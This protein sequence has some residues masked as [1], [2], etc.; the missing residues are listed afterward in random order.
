[1]KMSDLLHHAP[2]REIGV[3]TRG[4]TGSVPS[5]G[6]YE[7]SLERDL[8]EIL[9]FDPHVERFTPQPLTI[10]YLDRD[11]RTRNYTPDGL[12]HFKADSGS[13]QVP[14]L[15]EVKHRED[16]RKDWK[17]LLPKF[18]AAKA[19]CLVQ[20]WRFEVF[21]ER[22]IRTPY[23]EN[24]KFLWPYVERVPSPELRSQI[25]QTLSDLDEADPDLLLCALCHDAG[26][27]ARL[28]PSLWHLVAVGA[29]G[30]DLN[31]RLT[32]R[33]LIWLEQDC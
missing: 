22:E 15:F 11:G 30:C 4:V 31:V 1:M 18:R 17:I 24:V 27:R 32:M 14:V 3:S 19:Y 29:I 9:R 16:F 12:I 28:I 6:R 21:T 10:E 20:G 5:F 8:M 7:S 13:H 26:N 23:L 2:V 33:S 25:L